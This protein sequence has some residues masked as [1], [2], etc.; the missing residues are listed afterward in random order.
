M[1]TDLNILKKI[2]Q[3]LIDKIRLYKKELEDINKKLI[4]FPKCRSCKNFFI[5]DELRQLNIKELEQIEDLEDE[6]QD[7]DNCYEV[8]FY[9]Y[10]CIEDKGL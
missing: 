8:N 6:C 7:S 9:C 10:K 1:A 3:E 5:K 2:Q 4:E